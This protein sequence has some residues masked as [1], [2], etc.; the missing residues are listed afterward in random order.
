MYDVAIVGAGPAGAWTARS[1]VRL[2][3]R[4]LLL[5]GSHPREKPCGGGITGRA[6]ALVGDSVDGAAAQTVRITSA[7]FVDSQAGRG[8]SSGVGGR[9]VAGAEPVSC[10]VPLT[11]TAGLVVS[12]RRH[13]DS[14]LLDAACEAGAAFT[15]ARVTAVSRLDSG[16]HLRT[17]AG[18]FQARLLVGADGANSLVRRTFGTPLRRSQLSIA[19]GFYAHGVTSNEIVIELLDDPPGYLWSFPRP[20]HLAIGICA[21]ADAGVGP[22]ALRDRAAR[23]IR[24]TGLGVGATLA[25][26]SWPIPSLP[27]SDIPGATLHG[28][29]WL[30]VGDAAGLVDPITREGI[31]FA[32]QSGDFASTAIGAGRVD[33]YGAAV[34]RD[35]LPELTRAARLK[36]GFFRPRFRNLIMD[37]LRT[38]APVRQVMADLIAGTQPYR[39][40]KWRLAQTFEIGLAARLLNLRARDSR[41][42]PAPVP[43]DD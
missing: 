34:R 6:L 2:G 43:A 30:L 38:S 25:A 27:A 7:R 8:A 18:Q 33:R 21:Q 26:Y 37:A 24:D 15:P 5:D 16:F 10:A 14:R 13:F 20:N 23:W 4:V 19:T 29:D 9:R 32:L 22:G 3:A 28:T 36:D 1:L 35:I 31:F 40:L 41:L 12:S 17:T 11:S 39:G 42:W